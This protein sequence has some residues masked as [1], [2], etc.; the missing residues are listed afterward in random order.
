MQ[1]EARE[2]QERIARTTEQ[3]V[4]ED[5]TRQQHPLTLNPESHSRE[6]Q[7]RIPKPETRTPGQKHHDSYLPAAARV[8]CKEGLGPSSTSHPKRT[9]FIAVSISGKFDFGDLR[10]DLQ[11]KLLQICT[12]R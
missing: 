2:E 4:P 9:N 5:A 10:S 3:L 1:N 6:P 11:R 12:G 8:Q 7:A